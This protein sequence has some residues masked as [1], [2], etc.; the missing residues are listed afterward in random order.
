MKLNILEV[1]IS[2]YE[3]DLTSNVPPL[4]YIP[5]DL[6]SPLLPLQHIGAIPYKGSFFGTSGS[7]Q[8]AS[9]NPI[10]YG[11]N[12]VALSLVVSSSFGL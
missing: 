11:L 8:Y 2:I 10:L 4:F 3:H 1:W 9:Y 7:R 6:P 5:S 12:F